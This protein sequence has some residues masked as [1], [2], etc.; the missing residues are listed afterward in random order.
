MRWCGGDPG[1]TW[2]ESPQ[3]ERGPAMLVMPV[4][5]WRLVR[6]FGLRGWWL[7]RSARP[8]GLMSL[9]GPGSMGTVPAS[10][11][12]PGKAAFSALF[13]MEEFV[14][15]DRISLLSSRVFSLAVRSSS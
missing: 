2:W 5:L 12:C 14:A 1:V 4:M 10:C 15:G 13:C 8:M 3:V 6:A 7:S 9:R 11:S